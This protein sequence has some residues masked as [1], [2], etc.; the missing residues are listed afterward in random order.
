MLLL[1][2][3]AGIA[4][5][6][7]G[8]AAR[9]FRLAFAED[10]SDGDVDLVPNLGLAA[11]YIGDDD[12]ALDEYGR[13]VARA[14][15]A[16]APVSILYGLARRATAEIS[17]GDWHAAAA[18]SAEGLDLA[19]G[20]GQ[21]ALGSLPLAWLSLLAALRGDEDEFAACI[22]ESERPTRGRDVGLTSVVSREVMLWA[23][24]VRAADTPDTALHNLS[25]ITH[26]M[27]RNMSALDR[28]E[29]A[30]RAGRTEHV[31]DWAGELATLADLT[32]APWAQAYADHGRA[33]LA[34][35]H[36][37]QELFRRA[38]A[39]HARSPRRVDRARTEL[40]FGEFLRRSRRR[41]DAREHLRA[42]LETFEDV[43][44]ER[45]A[46]RARNELRASG[47]TSRKRDSATAVD[48]TPQERHVAE[49]VRQGLSTRDAAAQLFLSPRTVDFHLRNVFTKLGVSSR[50]ELAALDL[51]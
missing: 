15:A 22:T 30:A 24:G 11:L 45:W 16:G 51:S 35:G 28:L 23:R 49:L 50:A 2:G 8:A 41:V 19:R 1:A 34:E 3:F 12:V 43:G 25:Q 27:V 48:L 42:A 4:R 6:D 46:A 40:A 38:L 33:L 13:F 36:E 5:G 9:E 31:T 10:L 44:A 7:L 32:G 37:A 14:R 17:T 47:Q 18:S 39:A 20:T 29:A 26:P 21:D